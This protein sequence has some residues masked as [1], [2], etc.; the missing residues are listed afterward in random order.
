[1][2]ISVDIAIISFFQFFLMSTNLIFSYVILMDAITI[3]GYIIFIY[4]ILLSLYLILFEFGWLTHKAEQNEKHYGRVIP[5]IICGLCLL[6]GG[7]VGI[8]VWS[9]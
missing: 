2:L 1:M 4:V 8:M 5:G 3:I 7:I 6:G 9:S